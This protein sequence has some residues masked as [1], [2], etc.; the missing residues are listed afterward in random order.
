[1][2]EVNGMIIKFADGVCRES[3][4]IQQAGVRRFIPQHG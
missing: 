4:G 3:D 2:H 1:M